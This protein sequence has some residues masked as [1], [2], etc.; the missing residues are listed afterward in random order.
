MMQP[1]GLGALMPQG[2]QQAPQMNN[3]RLNAAVDVVSSDAEKQILDPRTLAMLKYKDALQAMQAADQMMAAAQP[4]P[5]PPTVAE[6]TKLAAEQG[7]AGL[8]SRLSPG[9]QRQGGN[10]Q[11]QQMQQ[12]MS[13]GLPQLSA[14]NMARM[15]GGGIVA[16]DNGGGVEGTPTREQLDMMVAAQRARLAEERAQREFIAARNR[17]AAAGEPIPQSLSEIKPFVGPTDLAAALNQIT[18]QVPTAAP[19]SETPEDT[20][21]QLPPVERSAVQPQASPRFD[22]TEE[23]VQQ[24]QPVAQPEPDALTEFYTRQLE[25]DPEAESVRSAARLRELAGVDDLVAQRREEQQRLRQMQEA[26]FSPE[27]S[28]RRRL[29][30][31]LGS[32]ARRGLGGFSAGI[33]EEEGRIFGEQEAVQRQALQDTNSLI[34]ELRAM[35]LSQFEAENVA[36]TAGQERQRFGVTGLEGRRAEEVAE[37]RAA[38]QN[39]TQIRAAE[40]AGQT[41]TDNML[42]ILTD[43]FMRTQNIPRSEAEYLAAEQLQENEMDIRRAAAAA[44]DPTLTMVNRMTAVQELANARLKSIEPLALTNRPQYEIERQ[45]INEDIAELT[46]E[47]NSGGIGAL[48]TP[49]GAPSLE[50]FLTAARQANPGVSEAELTQYYNENYRQ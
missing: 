13:G 10:M 25:I 9:I 6:R 17:A 1:Q 24:S 12:A 15:A 39:E 50:D 35:G 29:R 44:V 8:A 20:V 46:R 23:Y 21:A 42:R 7:I 19:T 33:T 48:R 3:P 18:Q 43:N 14:P 47:I 34:A 41:D 5:M 37:R 26:R 22:A 2:A 27:E 38:A 49:Q 11:A 31:G 45:A 30:A 32:L 40:I 16:F 36:R 28:R 4:Q